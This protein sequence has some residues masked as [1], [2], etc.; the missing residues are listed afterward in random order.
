VTD[1]RQLDI[2]TGAFSYT[3]REIARQLI[4]RGH[5]VKTLTRRGPNESPFGDRVQTLPFNFDDP[6]GLAASLEGAHTLYN[7]YWVRFAHG[8]VEF[9]DAVQN[10]KALIDAAGAAGVKRFVHVSIT[11]PTGDPSLPYF[12][13]KA[14]LEEALIDSG[15]S[16]G[17]VR[18][19]VIFGRGDVFINNVAWIL[20][21]FPVMGVPGDGQ[22]R[23]QPVHVDDVARIA[24]ELGS[25]QENL[26]RDA[27]GPEIFT[28]D[29]F[30]TTIG[31]GIGRGRPLVHL[32]VVVALAI[33]RAIG[34]L[35]HDVVVTREELGGLMAD[36]VVSDSPP[37]GEIKLT[38]WIREHA[39]TLGR[40]YSSELNRNF[41]RPL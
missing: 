1:D 10:T 25:A 4:P 34:L 3:G 35:V 21:H 32:P 36:L 26:I 9:S 16:Y 23:I 13:S 20:R 11:K 31:S 12:R 30:V 39:G 2:I 29:E 8:D 24:V 7:T 38:E 37:A 22:Y 19:T 6:S 17:I 28:W 41:R 27:A 18:P 5:D 40:T 15:L 33:A 14:L